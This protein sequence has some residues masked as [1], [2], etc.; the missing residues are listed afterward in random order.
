MLNLKNE[1]DR[2][3]IAERLTDA[4]NLYTNCHKEDRQF[5]AGNIK[6]F[7][8]GKEKLGISMS[9]LNVALNGEKISANTLNGLA[10]FLKIPVEKFLADNSNGDSS[11]QRGVL[12]IVRSDP[13]SLLEQWKKDAENTA[14]TELGKTLDTNI[15]LEQYLGF[16]TLFK[17]EPISIIQS[18][19]NKEKILRDLY[20]L[21]NSPN[22]PILMSINGDFLNN[23]IYNEFSKD[24]VNAL[25]DEYKISNRLNYRFMVLD[26]YLIKFSDET[27][28][29]VLLQYFSEPKLNGWKTWLFPHG[30]QK[31]EPNL[32]KRLQ[33]NARDLE[34]LIGLN[35]FDVEIKYMPEHEYL[36]SFKPDFGYE[37]KLVAYCFLFCSVSIKG[38]QSRLR[39]QKFEIQKGEYYRSFKWFY[40]E[41]LQNENEIIR[42]N[43]D[44][45]RGI[46]TLYGTS[47]VQIPLSLDDVKLL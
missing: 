44:I 32:G 42:K 34:K 29:D 37:D 36:L 26:L 45:V 33:L 40:P 14:T 22:F 19:P 10:E 11:S 30:Y 31:Q 5:I 39:Q 4:V 41:E 13:V 27:G 3:I 23:P 47:L 12:S 38:E 35:K 17:A 46:H 25:V 21:H 1:Q 8:H 43:S 28:Q 16:L 24:E 15:N 20:E 6:T 9:T 2:L 7:V 18:H